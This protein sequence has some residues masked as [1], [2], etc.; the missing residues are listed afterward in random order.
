MAWPLATELLLSFKH[1][2]RRSISRIG[3]LGNRQVVDPLDTIEVPH[4]CLGHEGGSCRRRSEALDPR[5]GVRFSASILFYLAIL[6]TVQD[7]FRIQWLENVIDLV[8]GILFILIISV[9]QD[10]RSIYLVFRRP[11]AA[12]GMS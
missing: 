5:H 12:A 2:G 3:G 9:S 7:V 10:R 4:E 6:R 11:G 8:D 1:W